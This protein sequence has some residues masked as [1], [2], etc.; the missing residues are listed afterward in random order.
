MVC[1]PEG[2]MNDAT[3]HGGGNHG[4][5]VFRMV[6]ARV[7]RPSDRTGRLQPRRSRSAQWAA[8]RYRVSGARPPGA[9]DRR[10]SAERRG[11]RR[12]A[13]ARGSRPGNFGPPKLR[14]GHERHDDGKLRHDDGYDRHGLDGNRH[15]GHGHR[16]YGDR[17]DD[18]YRKHRDHE[19]GEYRHDRHGHDRYGHDGHQ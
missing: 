4:A 16:N 18:G 19:H 6:V 8:E 5:K 15:D 17:N 7:R 1:T 13:L 11:W 2:P 12:L 9:G 14:F 10:R 3:T